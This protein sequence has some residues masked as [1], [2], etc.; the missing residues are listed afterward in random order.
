MTGEK[1]LERAIAFAKKLGNPDR[2]T[3]ILHR[4]ARVYKDQGR[5]ELSKKT[6]RTLLSMNPAFRNM[7]GVENEFLAALERDAS[8]EAAN[9]LKMDFWKKYNRKS[10]WAKSQTDP[11]AIAMADSLAEKQLYEATIGFH[12]LALQSNDTAAYARALDV[13]TDYIRSYPSSVRTSECHYNLAEIEFSLGHYLK[14]A[15]EYIAVPRRYP[16][17]KLKETAAWNAIVASQNL[18][19]KEGAIR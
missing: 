8:P 7:P 9:T 1:G 2:G 13:Y 12:Q 15:E 16:D 11:E 4:L 3:Q 5:Y 19:R 14:A 17:S 6:Y 10:A 18:L